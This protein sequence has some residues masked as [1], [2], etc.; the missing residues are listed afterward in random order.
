MSEVLHICTFPSNCDVAQLSLN[1]SISTAIDYSD[2]SM[3]EARS[4]LATIA[5]FTHDAQAYMRE[6]LQCQAVQEGSLFERLEC[7]PEWIFLRSVVT[8]FFFDTL[9][10]HKTTSL[11]P[12][13]K[14]IMSTSWVLCFT[15]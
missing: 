12:S 9:T 2:A 7:F 4:S 11:W 1:S 14:N 6:Q 5:T 3:I 13:S 8:T 15:G 10:S